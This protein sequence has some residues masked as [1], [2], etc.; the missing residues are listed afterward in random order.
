MFISLNKPS[1]RLNYFHTSYHGPGIS[2]WWMKI[3]QLYSYAQD[4]WGPP[5]GATNPRPDKSKAMV[6]VWCPNA[7]F[8]VQ[9]EVPETNPTWHGAD[10]TCNFPQTDLRPMSEIYPQTLA[11]FD[12][13]FLVNASRCFSQYLS[14]ISSKLLKLRPTGTENSSFIPP[15]SQN[16]HLDCFLPSMCHC[17]K[18]LLTWGFV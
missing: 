10:F 12:S 18:S 7:D 1:N 9:V 8:P 14:G 2:I 6:L 13:H 15:Q 3:V 11:C 17:R 4:Y 5:G 16:C